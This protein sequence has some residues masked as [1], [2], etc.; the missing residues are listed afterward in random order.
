MA[1]RAAHSITCLLR[2]IVTLSCGSQSN[3]SN[4]K[5]IYF[6]ERIIE[7]TVLHLVLST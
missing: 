4:K 1:M 5:G 3:L 7:A 2:E 6:L